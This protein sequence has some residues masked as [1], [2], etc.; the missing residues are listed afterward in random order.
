QACHD[1]LVDVV[2]QHAACRI[3]NLFVEYGAGCHRPAA[4]IHVKRTSLEWTIYLVVIAHQ[5]MK[6]FWH[7][8]IEVPPFVVD[9]APTVASLLRKRHTDD[10]RTVLRKLR[11]RLMTR[12]RY[13]SVEVSALIVDDAPTILALPRK[14]D[15]YD[16]RAVLGQIVHLLMALVRNVPV[17]VRAL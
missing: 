6:F 5:H 7:V 15:R 3:A 11:H 4:A 10:L 1:V 9:D 12:I 14:G 17:E 8:S 2:D 13:V 16:L